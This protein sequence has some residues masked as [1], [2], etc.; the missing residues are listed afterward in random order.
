MSVALEIGHRYIPS[1][2]EATRFAPQLPDVAFPPGIREEK[3]LVELHSTS[4]SLG[5]TVVDVL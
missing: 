2:Q 5:Q 4:A 1:A 3:H